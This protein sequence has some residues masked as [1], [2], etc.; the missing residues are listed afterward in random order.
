VIRSTLLW[1]LVLG[2][3]FYAQ[4]DWYKALC[5]LI[6]LVAIVEHPDMP[7]TLFGIQ[8]LN[9]WNVLFVAVVLAWL[10]HRGRE[11]LTWDMPPAVNI[12]VLVYLGVVAVGFVRMMMDRSALD[13]YTTS[14]LVSEYLVNT[15]KWVIPGLLLFD[16]ARTPAR[17]LTGL[18]CVAA[19]YL[20]LG[21]QVIRWMPLS[22]AFSGDAL[23]A[24]GAKI[25]LNEIGFHRV[26][27]SMMLA[28]ASWA[29][30]ATLALAKRRAHLVLILGASATVL[31]AQALTG[32]R[33]GYVTWA[34]LGFLLCVIRWHK[35]LAVLPALIVAIYLFAPAAFT[36]RMLQGFSPETRDSNPLL[37]PGTEN[38]LATDEGP[39]AYTITAGRNVAWPYIIDKIGESPIIGFGRLAMQ[40]T[41]L[42]FRLWNEFKE[43]FPHPHNAYLEWLLDNGWLGFVLV[44]PFYVLV[45]ARSVVLFR[46]GEPVRAAV[47]GVACALI[48]ALLVAS[49]GSQ[50]FYPREGA[51][52][53]WC[54]IGLMLRLSIEPRLTAESVPASTTPWW[55][56]AASLEGIAA[57]PSRGQWWSLS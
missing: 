36:E 32:G 18:G 54:A 48:L 35:Y 34:V 40:R 23:N 27:L 28:G 8:G 57:R 19:I 56:P 37:G 14:Y 43:S 11:G 15:V 5:G 39:D 51:V 12:L 41:G 33:M 17:V 55:R 6:V 50:T 30:V 9:P 10:A 16:G 13:E 26:N 3:S 4:R 46:D 38:L 29:L 52:G 47:G 49:F 24:R 22:E 45:V 31:Y 42:E 2:L 53:M 20:L 44:M 7:K 25:L 21:V 1:V